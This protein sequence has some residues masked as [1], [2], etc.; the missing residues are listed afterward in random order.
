MATASRSNID[1]GD[2]IAAEAC[3]QRCFEHGLERG[4]VRDGAYQVIRDRYSALQKSLESGE[5]ILDLL[6]LPSAEACWSCNRQLAASAKYCEDCGAPAHTPETQKLRYF[7]FVCN[8]IKKFQQDGTLPLSVANA[9]LAECNERLA[10]LGRALDRQ[11]IPMVEA[12]E[13]T[14]ANASGSSSPAEPR[15]QLLEILLDPRNIHMLLA[16]GGA[17]T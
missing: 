5:P 14:V 8:E 11:R 15:R 3:A 12:A 1:R 4:E 7:H 10:A 13:P 6:Q 16:F 17:L 9:C 2:L